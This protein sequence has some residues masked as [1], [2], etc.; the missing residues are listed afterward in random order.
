ML[1]KKHPYNRFTYSKKVQ[2]TKKQSFVL[3]FP[4]FS[5]IILDVVIVEPQVVV[6]FS[7]VVIK[8]EQQ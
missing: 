8:S 6:S 5:S 4:S 2:H 1:L 7:D 3:F